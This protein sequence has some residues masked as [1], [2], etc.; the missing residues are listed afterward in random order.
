[1]SIRAFDEL[2]AQTVKALD[3]VRGF[4]CHPHALGHQYRILHKFGEAYVKLHHEHALHH[5]KIEGKFDPK[6][7]AELAAKPSLGPIM[8]EEDDQCS[9]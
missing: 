1:M 4:G 7:L 3:E 5:V 9:T 2:I 8:R 6:F